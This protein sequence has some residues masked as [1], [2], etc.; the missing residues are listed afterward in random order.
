MALVIRHFILPFPVSMLYF[1]INIL[2][3]VPG[4]TQ[5]PLPVH[6]TILSALLSRHFHGSGGIVLRS[7]G[8]ADGRDIPSVILPEPF[9][10]RAG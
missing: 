8:A 6:D 4:W 2:F 9:S 3:Y 10:I 7:L 1:V 5:V